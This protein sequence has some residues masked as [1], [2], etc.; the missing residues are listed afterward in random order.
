VWQEPFD[1]PDLT[2]LQHHD[3]LQTLLDKAWSHDW[4]DRPKMQEIR[5]TF[6]QEMIVGSDNDDAT[7][8]SQRSSI[9]RH[10]GRSTFVF[11]VE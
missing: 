4:Q 6:R 8:L 5:T 10:R 2:P 1:R 3:K 7:R 9:R 11:P